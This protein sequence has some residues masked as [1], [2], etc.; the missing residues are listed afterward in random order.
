M[1]KGQPPEEYYDDPDE[2]G[3]YNEYGAGA[4]ADG[5]EDHDSTAEY[6]EY[7]DYDLY[8][9]RYEV[10]PDDAEN[11]FE[12]YDSVYHQAAAQAEAKLERP[13]RP[14]KA[15]PP[16]PPPPG[17]LRAWWRRAQSAALRVMLPAAG[18]ALVFAVFFYYWSR[19][20][21]D[22]APAQAPSFA[23]PVV[24]CGDGSGA[25]PQDVAVT[26]HTVPALIKNEL[27]W[28]GERHGYQ[29]HG[30]KGQVWQ[31]TVEARGESGL[32]P[33]VR[34]FDARGREVAVA[35]DRS[36]QDFAAELTFALAETGAYCVLVESSQGGL[37]SGVY[38]LSAWV[39]E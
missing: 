2:H 11:G 23:P 15:K 13:R 27:T 33:L 29:F 24:H 8:D 19:P 28:P 22:R 37:T 7:S 32:D 10:A 3:A 30:G 9:D 39:V 38:W 1:P 20:A 18:I 26:G 6:D 14:R 5:Y 34:L 31:I 17:P 21:P 16:A 4:D 36:A 12:L 25:W 35:D